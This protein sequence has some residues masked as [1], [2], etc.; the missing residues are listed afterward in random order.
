MRADSQ[1]TGEI[2]RRA[3]ERGIDL[4]MW[5]NGITVLDPLSGE[6]LESLPKPPDI[7]RIPAGCGVR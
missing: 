6:F 4:A 1:V 5:E 3:R 2:E 7:T